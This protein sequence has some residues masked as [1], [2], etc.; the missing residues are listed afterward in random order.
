MPILLSANDISKTFGSRPLFEGLTFV[1]ESGERI[2][3]IGPNG[4]GK[5]TLLR[6]MAGQTSVDQGDLSFQR[7]LSTGFLEQSPS[8]PPGVTVEEAVIAATA[9]PD[10]WES[11]ALS[12]E[13]IS[14]LA[15][16]PY[17]KQSVDTLSGGWKKRVALARELVKNPELL[18]LDEP[19]NH[20]DVESILWLEE[21]LANAKCH[22]NRYPRSA[23]FTTHR[24]P[25]IGT[26]SP[27]SAGPFKRTWGL[28]H[29]PRT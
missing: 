25:N 3:L 20:L 10:D 22:R 15:L 2:G 9:D 6:I 27:Q 4:A 14:K 24:Q 18:L 29:L 12:Q 8:L 28:R 23:I 16:E 11:M 13:L 7:G 17:S 26:R 1:V 19:T 21:F 5:S